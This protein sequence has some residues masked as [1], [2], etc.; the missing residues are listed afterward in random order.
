MLFNVLIPMGGCVHVC[1]FSCM[2]LL[3]SLKVFVTNLIVAG[4]DP[5]R[6]FSLLEALIKFYCFYTQD[7]AHNTSDLFFYR[8]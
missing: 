1:V 5:V 6:P 3:S 7:A 2:C 8:C 4:I